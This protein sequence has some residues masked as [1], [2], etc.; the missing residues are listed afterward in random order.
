L[1]LDIVL[2][3]ELEAPG[4]LEIF[5]ELMG[6]KEKAKETFLSPQ[7]AVQVKEIYD[8]ECLSLWDGCW[9]ES[10]LS[11]SKAHSPGVRRARRQEDSERRCAPPYG[12]WLMLL[13]G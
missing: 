12:R 4:L 3:S 1:A 13:L 7:L 11:R 5:S 2:N 10:S 8:S 9:R 6:S